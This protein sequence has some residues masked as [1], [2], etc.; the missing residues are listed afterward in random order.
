M[1]ELFKDSFIAEEGQTRFDTSF[2]YGSNP[3]NVY[4]NGLKLDPVTDVNLEYG[5]YIILYSPARAGDEISII[6]YSSAGSKGINQ[7]K[8]T[9]FDRLGFNFDKN[10]FGEAL[11]VNGLNQSF[12]EANPIRLK[13]WQKKFLKSGR[14]GNYFQNPLATTIEDV[15]N[16]IKI[17]RDTCDGVILACKP[18]RGVFGNIIN[19]PKIVPENKAGVNTLAILANTASSTMNELS[20]F[21]SH[22][23]RLSGVIV[24]ETGDPDYERAIRVGTNIS[25]I[26]NASD[27]I[28]D[29]SP[30]LGSFTSLF[31]KSDIENR[32]NQIIN[33]RNE[34]DEIIPIEVWNVSNYL[35]ETTITSKNWSIQNLTL[36]KT[37]DI[38]SSDSTVRASKFKPDGT[39]LYLTGDTSDT[40]SQ[41]DLTNAWDISTITNLKKLNINSSTNPNYI[42][43][44]RAL[45]GLDFS[46]DGKK[47]YHTDFN[48]N[49]LK[50][51]EY[52]LTEAWN[53]Q[54][55]ICSVGDFYDL[56]TSSDETVPTGVTFNKDGN[57]MYITGNVR[58]NI[59]QYELST[60]WK[61]S[62][63]SLI[64]SKSLRPAG[65]GVQF[66]PQSPV[67][68]YD[69]KKLLVIDARTGVTIDRIVHYS[70]SEAWNVATLNESEIYTIEGNVT[71]NALE[72]SAKGDSV[73]LVDIVSDNY[74]EYAVPFGESFNFSEN[75]AN[76]M[77][78]IFNSL[79]TDLSTRRTHDVQYFTNS[80]TLMSDFNKLT[81]L[82]N[83]PNPAAIVMI[84]D[85][86]GTDELKNLL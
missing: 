1:S 20:L 53:V 85:L 26:V 77:I 9:F 12:Y 84:R 64:R 78:R 70:L 11:T 21:K 82:V 46:Y 69:G 31:I 81:Q 48:G 45:I 22:T 51:F 72:L 34:N 54:S 83:I 35:E 2:E 32:T 74:L 65:F 40:I 61:V 58:D 15:K 38:S 37:A 60:P 76:N 42:G 41:Y 55:A 8:E 62:T 80:L 13:E 56:T 10:K 23:D 39:R 79:K 63:A 18:V 19:N 30:I 6:G 75:D 14:Y 47:M 29:F 57:F 27:G 50:V 67:F 17:I 7:D 49:N 25:Q 59:M 44:S 36:Q 86:I 73:F 52:N 4:R 33:F 3:I 16:Y 68:S 28:T 5:T 71:M 43:T 66:N 24:S